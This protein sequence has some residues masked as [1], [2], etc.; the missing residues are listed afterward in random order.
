[1]NTPSNTELQALD[2]LNAWTIAHEPNNLGGTLD[3]YAPETVA[4]MRAALDAANLD[5]TRLRDGV[6][7]LMR[8][9]HIDAANRDQSRKPEEILILR[10]LEDRLRTLLDGEAKG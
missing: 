6:K 4:A 3:D 8:V 10:D 1:M 7:A 2:A 9:C 5:A